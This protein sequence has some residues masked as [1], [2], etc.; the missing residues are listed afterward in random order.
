M[1]D[2][3]RS[4]LFSLLIS[5]LLFFPLQC[6]GTSPQITWMCQ[7]WRSYCGQFWLTYPAED[8]NPFW[9]TPA[10]WRTIN[11]PLAATMFSSLIDLETPLKNRKPGSL[12]LVILLS[13]TIFGKENTYITEEDLEKCTFTS[14]YNARN[15]KGYAIQGVAAIEKRKPMCDKEELSSLVELGTSY[16]EDIRDTTSFDRVLQLSFQVDLLKFSQPWI[17]CSRHASS[18]IRSTEEDVPTLTTACFFTNQTSVEYLNDPCCNINL[19]AS[20]C[21]V[22]RYKNIS[23]SVFQQ[24]NKKEVERVCSDPKCSISYLNDWKTLNQENFQ[25]SRFKR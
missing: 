1:K 8:P 4:N 3:Q 5:L 15:K 11:S 23:T 17:S 18:L 10:M 2:P 22:P 12:S 20:K 6:P 9:P 13:N 7:D 14:S 25:C 16:L 24:V 21:C 19:R